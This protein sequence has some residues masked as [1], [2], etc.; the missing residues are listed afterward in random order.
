M[1]GVSIRPAHPV[2]RCH[3]V[4]RDPQEIVEVTTMP[5]CSK[6]CHRCVCSSGLSVTARPASGRRFATEQSVHWTYQRATLAQKSRSGKAGRQPKSLGKTVSSSS[7]RSYALRRRR[8]RLQTDKCSGVCIHNIGGRVRMSCRPGDRAAGRAV[9]TLTLGPIWT[10]ATQS[11]R[12]G[13]RRCEVV[14]VING[15]NRARA[16][17]TIHWLAGEDGREA[18]FSI[19]SFITLL[20]LP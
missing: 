19:T 6:P 1:V 20:K 10:R 13:N 14:P 5:G 18:R 12:C 11:L 9:E 4:R 8:S 3:P 17:P 2:N 16:T 15:S 7:C